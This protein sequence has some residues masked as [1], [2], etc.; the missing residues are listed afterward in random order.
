MQEPSA[1]HA[2]QH[3]ARAPASKDVVHAGEGAAGYWLLRAAAA[4][5]AYDMN[6]AACAALMGTLLRTPNRLTSTRGGKQMRGREAMVQQVNANP[7]RTGTDPTARFL[8]SKLQARAF[9]AASAELR[10]SGGS[11]S[12]GA[13]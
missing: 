7:R 2:R 13:F 5:A 3:Y 1:E 12:A 4:S 9:G 6:V 10:P 8:C 11:R